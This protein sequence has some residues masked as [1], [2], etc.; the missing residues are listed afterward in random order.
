MKKFN[1][2]AILIGISTAINGAELIS[3]GYYPLDKIP[4]KAEINTPVYEDFEFK[5]EENITTGYTWQ[6]RYNP[7]EVKVEIDHDINKKHKQLGASGHADI[8]VE[9]RRDKAAIV[10][11][12]Y[13]RP[14]EKDV[15][16][17][18]TMTC[19]INPINVQNKATPAKV[20]DSTIL[21]ILKDDTYL[22]LQS[23][24]SAM[25][26]TLPIG[27][28]ISFD[29]E[30]D[31]RNLR[32]WNIASAPTPIAEIEIDH[33]E[34]GLFF[35]NS[36]AEIE[37][38]PKKSGNYELKLIYAKDTPLEKHFTLFITVL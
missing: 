19:T 8:E 12:Y 25:Q 14:F 3:D 4:E 7:Q 6:A 30:E 5:L 36:H 27:K 21:P 1:L 28:D 16:P 32:F 38:E 26:V 10:E 2:L 9:L 18:K 24:P 29:I 31:D 15:K 23:M 37:I 11:F 34:S 35:Q 20:T 17:L 13:S 22:K 33:E